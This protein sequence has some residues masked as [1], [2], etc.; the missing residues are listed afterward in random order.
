MVSVNLIPAA[1]LI[2]KRR[3]ARLSIWTKVS[4][5]Y[6]LLL[7]C[8]LGASRWIWNC[9]D[10]AVSHQLDAASRKIEDSAASITDLQGKLTEARA[11]LNAARAVGNQPDWSALLV[12]LTHKLEDQV[13]LDSCELR[14]LIDEQTRSKNG[15]GSSETAKTQVPLGGRRYEL[16]L[17]GYGRTQT[18]VSQFVLRLERIDLFS[19]IK[20][21]R[22]NRGPFMTQEAVAFCIEC[23]M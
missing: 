23:S 16:V 14:P 20:L 2:R 22:S 3:H 18:A 8:A 10:A 9:D 5:G 19:T 11:T 13:V 7:V 12:L 15:S 1:R 17:S 4:L 21:T 6:A